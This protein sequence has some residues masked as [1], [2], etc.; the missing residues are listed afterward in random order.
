LSVCTGP[1]RCSSG[2]RNPVVP[3]LRRSYPMDPFCFTRTTGGMEVSGDI[4]RSSGR[5][6]N[7]SLPPL[8]LSRDSNFC[9]SIY[10]QHSAAMFAPFNSILLLG[11]FAVR[12]FS[13]DVG[14]ACSYNEFSGWCVAVDANGQNFPDCRDNG[15]FFMTNICTQG[16]PPS[17]QND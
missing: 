11:L 2:V 13:D 1:L 10:N 17:S 7:Y 4:L 6:Y 8:R 16:V 14:S 15:G 5:R 9:S 12:S 3:V